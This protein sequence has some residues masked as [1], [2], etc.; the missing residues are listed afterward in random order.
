MAVLLQPLPD[1]TQQSK[2]LQI[3]AHGFVVFLYFSSYPGV[4]LFHDSSLLFCDQRGA[5]QKTA[6]KVQTM[7]GKQ[8]PAGGH[9]LRGDGEQRQVVSTNLDLRSLRQARK[10]QNA[11]STLREVRSR[12]LSLLRQSKHLTS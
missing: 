5:Q 3:R 9:D 4:V 1:V 2:Y 7:L 11:F 6:K 12:L 10:R 8:P